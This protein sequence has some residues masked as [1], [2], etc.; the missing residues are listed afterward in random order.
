MGQGWGGVSLA[1]LLC[2]LRVCLLN[3]FRI[4]HGGDGGASI[5][6]TGCQKQCAGNMNVMRQ[7]MLLLLQPSSITIVILNPT[8]L[9]APMLHGWMMKS[10]GSVLHIKLTFPPISSSATDVGVKDEQH[11][12]NET[13]IHTANTAKV[14]WQHAINANLC[15]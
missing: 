3:R 11:V 12:P 8:W 1:L 9:M 15:C 7:S 6:T 10:A 14:I 4:R 2:C 13:E 5:G